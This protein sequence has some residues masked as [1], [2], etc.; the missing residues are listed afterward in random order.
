MET[1]PDKAIELLQRT[2]ESVKAAGLPEAVTR[3]Q[4][5]RISIAI[6]LAKKDKVA[7]DAKMKDKEGCAEIEPSG[8]DPEADKAKK[9]QIKVLME[10]AKRTWPTASMK[11]PKPWPN[12]GQIDPNDPSF[13]AFSDRR[14]PQA[15]LRGR[16]PYPRAEGRVGR[17][18]VQGGR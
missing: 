1:D 8:S 3:S 16:Y 18:D 12:P 14:S 4:T 13:V 2:L 7:F 10:K 15:R 11:R 6:E 17:R 9:D 5:S